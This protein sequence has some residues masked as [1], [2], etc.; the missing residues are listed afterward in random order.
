[1]R[2]GW[3]RLRSLWRSARQGRRLDD[4]MAA[5]FR[6]HIDL[7]TE[8]LIR[9]GVEPREAARRARLEFGAPERY[10]EEGRAAR[11]LRGLDELRTDLRYAARGLIRSPGY[12]VV[13]VL[14][15][16]LGV[17]A[18]AAVFSLLSS[19]L[20]RPLPFPD[21]D[22]L[23]VIHQTY[24]GAPGEWVALPWSYPEY[25]AVR[26]SA[27]GV[28]QMAAYTSAS[29]NVSVGS[30]PFRTSLEIVSASY[31]GTLG[32]HPFRG[33]DFLADEDVPGAA[34]V[35]MVSHDFWLQH[36]GG[37]TDAGP[38]DIVINGLRFA[39]I[40]VTP[41]GFRGLTGQAELW[42]L[43]PSAPAVYLNGYLTSDQRFISVI[44][45][46]RPDQSLENIRAELGTA[47]LRATAAA[48]AGMPGS[49]WSG[50]WGVGAIAL[51]EAR[52]DPASL[53]AQLVLAGAVFFVLLM[54][55][56]NLFALLLA[57]SSVRARETAVRGALG[58]GRWR[59]VRH[60]AVEGALLGVLGGAAGI[61]LAGWSVRGLVAMSPVRDAWTAGS[62][63]QLGSLAAP[64]VDWR[65]VAF[66]A[67]LSL[68]AGVAACVL[69]VVRATRGDFVRDLR[70]GA[71]GS[72]ISVGSL[73]RPTVLSMATVVQVACALVLLTGAGALLQEFRR[74]TAHDTGFEAD[75]VVTFRI[76]PPDRLYGGDAA[77]PLLERVL[78]HIEA[79]PGVQSAT[80]SLC[81]PFAQCSRAS[82]FM[83]GRNGVAATVGRHYVGPDH[84]RTL[85]IPLLRGRAIT[86]ADRLDRPLVAVVNET[87]A[88]QIWPDEDPIGQRVWF[89]SGV[90]SP[91]TS[92]EIVGVVGDVL[93]G[94]PGEEVRPD[95]YTPYLQFTWANTTVMVKTARGDPLQ[96]VPALRHAVLEADPNLP[97]H[98]VQRLTSRIGDVL[99]AERFA[100]LTLG[101][102][103]GLGLLLAVVGVY[104]I[105]AFAVAQRRR[106]VGIRMALGSTPRDVQ[107]LLVRQGAQLLAAGLLMGAVAVYWLERALPALIADV[108]GASHGVV[109]GV[110][111]L[112]AA[113]GLVACWLPARHAMAVDPATTLSA[114]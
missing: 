102:F 61:A 80:V 13:A 27:S 99:A 15:L 96:L 12:A 82:L 108:D 74:L 87:A 2:G 97:I 83:E 17:G 59:I 81:P 49:E 28:Q 22:R 51:A 33:R 29:V 98:D 50:E 23:A 107:R 71:R 25:E 11:G 26:A 19:Q 109:L 47:G 70:V 90:G 36:L 5:E 66:A 93:Y 52:R 56:V 68:C 40:G 39:L 55:L 14:L 45:R 3:S 60:A 105:M 38:R 44:G 65:V 69:P 37:E 54:A 32:L 94:R 78:S 43:H 35:A 42:V 9:S 30:E 100:T 63:A 7:R 64:A 8:D 77:A 76:S 84:F 16:G 113:A 86:D 110:A 72:S 95:F 18:N 31:L 92:V 1:M 89:A 6:L 57:R 111:A 34:A 112:L 58:A 46:L 62:P 101:V 21:A 24:A 4:D 88:R 67:L 75:G 106:E 103:A 53:R 10:V 20:L 85:G 73:R 79:V 48:R 91:D 104:G 41:A 114:D